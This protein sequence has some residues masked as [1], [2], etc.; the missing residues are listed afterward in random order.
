[1]DKISEII[2]NNDQILTAIINNGQERGEIRMDIEAKYLS[3]AVMGILRL[4][5][6]KWQFSSYSFNLNQEGKNIIET[7]KLLVTK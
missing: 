1:V 7:V 5:V 3:I 6:K 2:Q 4:Y